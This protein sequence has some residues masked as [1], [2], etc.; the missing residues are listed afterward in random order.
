MNREE[1]VAVADRRKLKVAVLSFAH[2]H[3]IGYSRLLAGRDDIE[4]VITDPDGASAPDDSPRGADLAGMLGVPYVHSY[5]EALAWG[6][7]AVIVTAENARHRSLVEQAAAAGAHILCEKPLATTVDDARA[8]VAAAERAGVTLMTAYPVRFA[9]SFRDAVA[10][11]RS[12]QLGTVVGVKGT[13]NGKIPLAD[14]AWF[15]DPALSGGGALVDHVVHCAD[16]LDELLG[17]L[18]ATVRAVSNRM[19]HAD[20][21]VQVETGGLV[22]AVYPSGV[23]AT[24]DCS[25]SVPDSAATWGGV[26][27]QITGTRGTITVAPF[28]QHVSGYDLGGPVWTGTGD[29]LDAAMLGEFLHAVREGRP[30]VPGGDVGVRTLQIV[31]AAQASAATGQPVAV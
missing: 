28:A 20:S 15:T 17:E 16:L 6:P 12:G 22:T 13:N 4:L 9:S 18:P 25:W 3:A 29:D 21:G 5:E 23:V 30:A 26:T 7:D 1:E 27:L 11:V 24:I 19:L 2:T 8:M 31:A 10:R 14:R